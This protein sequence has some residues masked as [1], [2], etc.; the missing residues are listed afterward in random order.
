MKEANIAVDTL[1]QS[2]VLALHVKDIAML[3]RH[4]NACT[5]IADWHCGWCHFNNLGT[6]ADA[7]AVSDSFLDQ[8]SGLPITYAST[9]TEH[10]NWASPIFK[11]HV[12]AG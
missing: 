11:N 7:T 9:T 2:V 6:V 8:I 12:R 5:I 10:M 3:T 4:H 1:T